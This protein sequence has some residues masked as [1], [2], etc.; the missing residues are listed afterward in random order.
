[1]A[2]TSSSSSSSD[3]KA[4]SCFKACTK[5]YATLQS[6]YDKLTNDLRKSQFDVLS[7]KTGLESVE[8]RILV[9]QQNETVFEKDI[10]LLKL[11]VKL[12]DNDLVELRKKFEKAEQ[13]KDELKLKLEKFQTSSRNLIYD[14]YKLR[15]GYHAVPPLITRTFMPSKP[16]LVFYDATNSNRPSTPIIEDWVSN[17]EDESEAQ[18]SNFH[19]RVTTT[20]A[21]KVNV[22]KGVQGNWGNPQHALKDKGVIDSGCSRNMTGN[23]FYLS[24]FE[25][26]NGGY[27]AFE[28]P[29]ATMADTRTMSELLQAPTEGYEDA[30][31]TNL[32]NDI[33]NF[34]QRFDETFT[35]AWD[36]FKD[37]LRKCQH[38][39]FLELHQIDTFYNAL[40]QSDQDSLN[41]ATGGNLLNRTPRDALTIIG[42][43]S[44]VGT[45]RNKPI[46]SK[47]S[48]TTSSTTP[49]YLPKITALTDAVKTMLLQNKTPSPASVKA[50]EEIYVTCRGPHPYYECLATDGNTFNASATIGTYNKGENGNA[51]PITKVVEGVETTIPPTIAEEKAQRML[52]L[53]AR[54][55]LLMGIPNEH[56]LKFNSIKDAKSLLQAIEKIFRGNAATKKTQRNLLKQQNKPEIY[57]LSL[58]D[59]YNN[60]KI[61]EPEVKGTSSSN[62]NTQNLAFVSSNSTSNTNGAVNTAHGSTTATTQAT[63]VNSTTFDNLSDVGNLQMDLQDKGVI[64]SRCSRYIIGNMS[65]LTDYKE[66]DGGYVAFGGNPKGGKITGK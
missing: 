3:N 27:V 66:I 7:Y 26:I 11:D 58:D 22:V 14:R 40:M 64:D 32:K 45:S 56:Q 62:T 57:T 12:R 28:T 18:A 23:M 36:R 30:I 63:A 2:F 44:N 19:Q 47:A 5:A 29:I 51:P 60:L 39:G 21:P 17:S 65:C 4:A 8:A 35:E 6:H 52:E 34:Q 31:T 37:L 13:E 55:T 9:Y 25:E 42:N 1:M 54:S 15:E 38:H 50:I 20:K 59:L 33:T 16:D 41:E 49:A 48:A 61:Y 53:K 24:D 43:K 46:V 10:K